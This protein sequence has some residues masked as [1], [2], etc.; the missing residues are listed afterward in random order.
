MFCEKREDE[1]SKHIDHGW[2]EYTDGFR[3]F[4]LWII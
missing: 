3:E 4:R 2:K 1:G